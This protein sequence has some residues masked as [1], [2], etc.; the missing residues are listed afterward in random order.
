MLAATLPWRAHDPSAR[1]DVMAAAGT[2]PPL[3]SFDRRLTARGGVGSG[4]PAMKFRLS[5]LDLLVA[6]LVLALIALMLYEV[7]H[8]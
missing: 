3:V 4:Q 2:R 6:I 8:T 1:E 5:A 7:L